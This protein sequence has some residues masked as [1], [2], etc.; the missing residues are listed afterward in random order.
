[1]IKFIIDQEEGYA[2]SDNKTKE[3]ITEFF[4]EAEE[5]RDLTIVAG[6]ELAF[7][8]SRALVATTYRHL[9][10]HIEW[11]IVVNGE[12]VPIKISRSGKVSTPG[13]W[14]GMLTCHWENCAWSLLGSEDDETT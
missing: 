7:Y 3:C 12:Q 9:Y 6:T 2:L 1:M 11:F 4:R 5:S 14:D 13:F 10:D 8:Y